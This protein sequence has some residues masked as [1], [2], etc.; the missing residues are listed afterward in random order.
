MIS[1]AY[2]IRLDISGGSKVSVSM[3]VTLNLTLAIAQTSTN[4][5]IMYQIST[6]MEE[7]VNSPMFC[8][9]FALDLVQGFLKL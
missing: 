1:L 9:W 8:E 6:A 2:T 5:A 4:G 7:G 3:R